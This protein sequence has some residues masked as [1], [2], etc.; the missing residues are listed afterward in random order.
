[1]TYLKKVMMAALLVAT[2]AMT[3]MSAQAVL[4]TQDIFVTNEASGAEF[5]LGSVTIDIA[6]TDLN[7]GFVSAFDFVSFDIFGWDLLEIYGFEAVVD[8]DNVFAGIEF[9]AFDV[10]ELGLIDPWN[11]QLTFDAFDSGAN[12]VDIFDSSFDLVFFSSTLRLGDVTAVPEP[13]AIA[14]IGL[15]LM[16]MVGVRRRKL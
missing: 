6:D 8:G 11:Y 5:Q 3:S 2:T 16:T 10:E 1:M 7:N 4:I 13:S 12:F 14:L 9:L 15:A